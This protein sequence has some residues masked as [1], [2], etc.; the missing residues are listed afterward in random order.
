MKLKVFPSVYEPREDSYLLLEY[1]KC[2]QG[3]KVLDIGCGSGIIA[4]KAA[5]QGA[6]VFA[7]DLNPEAVKNT[8]FNARINNVKI[9]C[10]VGNLFD[11]LNTRIKFDKIFFNP[12]YLPE[13]PSDKYSLAWAGGKEGI[14]IAKKFIIAAKDF[15]SA[16]GEIFLVISSSGNK[17]RFM[18]IV[19]EFYTIE[20]LK[21]LPLFFEK[22]YLLK[23]TFKQ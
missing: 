14:E 18:K 20:I 2:K 5:L 6:K 10:I 23:L 9:Y 16:K 12:P 21:E 17:E 8:L 13:M 15:L 19:K 3:E 7:I 11:P 4:I 1:V 22:L